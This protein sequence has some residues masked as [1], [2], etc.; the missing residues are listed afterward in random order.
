MKEPEQEFRPWE[1]EKKSITDV[2]L[3]DVKYNR[4]YLSMW[5]F[6]SRTKR[7]WAQL[8]RKRNMFN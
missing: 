7:G 5:E 1:Y 8:I 4:H 3:V 6:L 2:L